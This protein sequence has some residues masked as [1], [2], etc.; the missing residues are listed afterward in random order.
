MLEPGFPYRGA[1]ALVGMGF[2]AAVVMVTVCCEK[3]TWAC[4]DVSCPVGA[5]GFFRGCQFLFEMAK[6]SGG[7]G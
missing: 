5:G 6:V 2:A 7:V 3:T 1:Q 4:C